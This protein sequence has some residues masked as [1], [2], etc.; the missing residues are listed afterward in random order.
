MI[1][2]LNLFLVLFFFLGLV[3]LYQ[4]AAFFFGFEELGQFWPTIQDSEQ[5]MMNILVGVM[6]VVLALGGWIIQL[7]PGKKNE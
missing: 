7:L 3:G 1:V 6:L 4:G 5:A 2:V